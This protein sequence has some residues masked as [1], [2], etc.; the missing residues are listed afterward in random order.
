LQAQRRLDISVRAA[1]RDRT[2]WWLTT[3]F[4]LTTLAAVAITIHLI[5]YLLD[6]GY[7]ARF[8]A[9]AASVIGAMKFPGRLAFAPLERRMP[10]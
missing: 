2:F 5:P 1:L 10:H 9:L 6:H 3:G 7:N 4:T 8:A